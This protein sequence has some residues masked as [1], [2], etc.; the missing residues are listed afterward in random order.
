MMPIAKRRGV[1]RPAT[2]PAVR[3]TRLGPGDSDMADRVK[4]AVLTK[5]GGD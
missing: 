4:L 1:P 3:M 2:R 5:G